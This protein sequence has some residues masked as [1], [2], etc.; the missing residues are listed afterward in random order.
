M[1]GI[2][3]CS[4]CP[5][6]QSASSGVCEAP[7]FHRVRLEAEQ[8]TW[9]AP[10]DFAKIG[11]YRTDRHLMGGFN[12]GRPRTR[13]LVEDCLALDAAFL[14]RIG[15]LQGL[16]RRRLSW[17]SNGKES[18]R[19]TLEV[20]LFGKERPRAV[21]KM[22][23]LAPQTI[24]LA[25]TRPN[26]GGERWWFL[27]PETGRRCRVLYLTTDGDRFVSRQAANLVYRSNG[28]G[29]ADSIR[30][31]AQQLRDTLPGAKY[32]SYPPRPRGMHR[33]KYDRI[34]SRLREA[35][36]NAQLVCFASMV[37]TADRL[38]IVWRPQR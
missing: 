4:Y 26:I 21:L 17:F 28:L 36:K 29:F 37:K 20:T 3:K 5:R 10:I 6:K 24:L 23:G 15:C 12:S 13:V 14:R 31:R 11:I 27:C 19:A 8:A 30:W 25:S 16:A 22:G 34:V 32:Q 18:A 2:R 35:D 9:A 7:E 1:G 38:G 33:K